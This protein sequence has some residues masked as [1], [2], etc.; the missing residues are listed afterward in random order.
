[1]KMILA[2]A[3]PRRK[4]LLKM[5]NIPFDTIA[6]DYE[7]TIDTSKPLTEEIKRLAYGKAKTVFD[8]HKD[9][10]IIGADTIV[11]INNKILGKPKTDSKAFEMLKE[12]SGNKHSVITGICIYTKDKIDTFAVVSYVYFNKMNTQEINDYI[13]TKEPLDKA[14]GYAIQGYASKF[15]KKIDGDFY[16]IMGLPVSALYRHLKDFD[17]IKR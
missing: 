7:E 3:S 1:M 12:L 14:G 11:T 5:L 10:L 13:L 4:E 9:D 17:F 8:M 16:A 15:I 6:S 2:S